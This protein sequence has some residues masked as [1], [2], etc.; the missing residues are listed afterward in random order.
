MKFVKHQNFYG[1]ETKEIPSVTGE[2]E[3]SGN[4][5]GVVGSLYTDTL[6]GNLYKCTKVQNTFKVWHR[7]LDEMEVPNMDRSAC[8]LMC[9]NDAWVPVHLE[10]MAQY[11]YKSKTVP[12]EEI[13]YI[14]MVTR[15]AV[16]DGDTDLVDE[17][18]EEWNADIFN[19]GYLKCYR[20]GTNLWLVIDTSDETIFAPPDCHSLFG[21]FSALTS[22]YGLELLNTE[23][24]T[25]MSN[26][27]RGDSSL[28]RIYGPEEWYTGAVRDMSYMFYMCGDYN[29]NFE[30]SLTNWDV[31]NVTTMQSMFNQCNM[32]V[33]TGGWD[34]SSVTTMGHMFAE[35]TSLVKEIDVSGWNTSNVTNMSYMFS[36]TNSMGIT[37]LDL[38]SWDTRKVTN[39]TNI[40]NNCRYL[41]EVVIGEA[42]TLQSKL[43][44]PNGSLIPGAD[45]KWHNRETGMSYT[46]AEIPMNVAA[47]YYATAQ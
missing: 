6:T 15:C 19:L 17:P 7:L 24:V 28:Q 40:F 20:V 31:S 38:S 10:T 36:A 27:F 41:Q 33:A 42:F 39:S 9:Y 14:N 30:L 34:T 1:T 8:V 11:W 37:K 5:D 26:M 3:P 4:T 13:T 25:S 23:W 29:A 12:Q 22:I 35:R 44:K 47:T 16:D 2:G 18:E 32:R 21:G 45:G 43:P 46:P